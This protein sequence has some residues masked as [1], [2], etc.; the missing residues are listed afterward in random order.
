MQKACQ[1]SYEK[2]DSFIDLEVPLD[3]FKRDGAAIQRIEVKS[4]ELGM[5][6]F[7]WLIL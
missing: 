7:T 5:T 3:L 1:L 2:R 4:L 6:N